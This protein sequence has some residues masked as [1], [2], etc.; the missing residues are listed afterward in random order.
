MKGLKILIVDDEDFLREILKEEFERMENIVFE[1]S[2]GNKAFSVFENNLDIDVILTDA[3][4][5]DGDGKSL[6]KKINSLNLIKKPQMFICTGD[7][8]LISDDIDNFSGFIHKPYTIDLIVENIKN[9]LKLV[10]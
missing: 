1:A 6:L 2:S 7:T 10:S 9:K 4:M 8:D 3:R 5:P